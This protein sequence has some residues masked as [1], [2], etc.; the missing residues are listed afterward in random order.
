VLL[1]F[2]P[3]ELENPEDDWYY[4]NN[5]DFAITDDYEEDDDF[6]EPEQETGTG[7]GYIKVQKPRVR[8]DESAEEEII[9]E[10]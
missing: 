5:E 3:I 2:D 10:E 7:A 9:P 6:V 1:I 8:Q 4:N